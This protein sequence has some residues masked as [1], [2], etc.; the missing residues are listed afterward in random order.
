[1]DARVNFV[2]KRPNFADVGGGGVKKRKLFADVLYGWPGPLE[3]E[4][5]TKNFGPVTGLRVLNFKY[6]AN[7][8]QR[9]TFLI[10]LGAGEG[11]HAPL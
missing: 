3:I 5:T 6:F 9:H 7:P 2:C 4:T 10:S 1:M 8:H 11:W